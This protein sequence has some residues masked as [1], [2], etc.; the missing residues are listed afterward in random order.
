MKTTVALL[1]LALAASVV[2]T[3]NAAKHARHHHHAA[4]V[5][6]ASTASNSDWPGNPYMDLKQSQVDRFWRDA[7]NPLG[8]T[9]K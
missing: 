8:A 9:A 1:S 6:H 5:A 4:H 7:F 2:N 3:A